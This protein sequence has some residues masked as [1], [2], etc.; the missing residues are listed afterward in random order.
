M[1]IDDI[2]PAIE[3]IRNDPTNVDLRGQAYLR[4]YPQ[5]LEAAANADNPQSRLLAAASSAYS[6][7]PRI[8]RLDPAHFEDAILA[9]EGIL[10]AD[11]LNADVLK[12]VAQC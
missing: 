3:L 5:H 11:E 9:T 2:Q 12:P 1:H 6:W 4:T 10:G 8:L 7:M